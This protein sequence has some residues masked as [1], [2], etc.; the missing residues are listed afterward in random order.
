MGETNNFYKKSTSVLYYYNNVYVNFFWKW[1]VMPC[2]EVTYITVT[3][4]FL[5]YWNLKLGE[6]NNFYKKRHKCCTNIMMI[7][8]V[9]FENWLW[10]YITN[11][12]KLLFGVLNWKFNT[13]KFNIFL[14]YLHENFITC[15]YMWLFLTNRFVPID[16]SAG[17]W[18][19]VIK[20]T[21]LMWSV[22]AQLL[23]LLVRCHFTVLI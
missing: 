1:T 12:D 5:M 3:N 23:Q 8:S 16:H 14:W 6:T 13:P 2:F 18:I 7:M 22:N 15:C 11:R 21:C 9:S 19:W 10:S 17:F 4:Y 20:W